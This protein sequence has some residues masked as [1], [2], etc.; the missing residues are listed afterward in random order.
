MK[1]IGDFLPSPEPIAACLTELRRDWQNASIVFGRL[2]TV[3]LKFFHGSDDTFQPFTGW[4]EASIMKLFLS[5]EIPSLYLHGLRQVDAALGALRPSSAAVVFRSL[6]EPLINGLFRFHRLSSITG[7]GFTQVSRL[8]QNPVFVVLHVSICDCLKATF[9]VQV[10]SATFVAL[11]KWIPAAIQACGPQPMPKEPN[12]FTKIMSPSIFELAIAILELRVQKCTPEQKDSLMMNSFSTFLSCY[13]QSPSYFTSHYLKWFAY[14]FQKHN[15]EILLHM[16]LNAFK[17]LPF[18]PVF[19]ALVETRKGIA[20]EKWFAHLID[21]LIGG[22]PEELREGFLLLQKGA[23]D[24][25]AI[26]VALV[27]LRRLEVGVAP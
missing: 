13:S 18:L 21:S 22:V 17:L 9:S 2:Q 1:V 11:L 16:F 3:H 7:L 10:N 15:R 4:D 20:D 19:L 14:T 24:G 6:Y 8:F 23:T 12:L 27:G 5:S 25:E 26:K